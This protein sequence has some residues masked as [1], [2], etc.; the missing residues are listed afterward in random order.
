[1]KKQEGITLIALVITIIVL[2]ILA[3]V[4]IAMLA[5]DNG[6]LNRAT[7]SRAQSAL[8][9]A[10]DQ[11]AIY[12]AN[13][14]SE[15]YEE[16]YVKSN[17]SAGSDANAAAGQALTNA[18]TAPDLKLPQGVSITETSTTSITLKY[19]ADNTTSTGKLT[20]GVLEWDKE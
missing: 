16:R 5:G 2:L 3:G 20:N 8:G 7:S 13:A 11:V 10:R 9:D 1:M 12:V 14:V 4:T 15:Y 6:I 17:T 19:D 18:K